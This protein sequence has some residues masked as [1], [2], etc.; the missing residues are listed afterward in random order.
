[1]LLV[2]HVSVQLWVAFKTCDNSCG[3]LKCSTSSTTNGSPTP[4]LGCTHTDVEDCGHSSPQ[5]VQ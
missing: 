4:P 2:Y 1:M 5:R 3:F